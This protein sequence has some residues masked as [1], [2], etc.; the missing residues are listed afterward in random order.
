MDYMRFLFVAVGMCVVVSMSAQHENYLND[1]MP[2]SWVFVP[3]VDGKAISVDDKWWTR[4]DD[5]MLDSLVSAAMR[6][7]YDIRHAARRVTMARA[8]TSIARSEFYPTVDLYAAA[9]TKRTSGRQSGSS[10][11]AD[12]EGY[13]ELGADINWQVDL[14]GKISAKTD[15]KKKLWQASQAEWAGVMLTVAGE[16]VKHYVNLRLFQENLDILHERSKSQLEIVRFVEE[17]QVGDGVSSLQV[18]QALTLYYSMLAEVPVVENLVRSEINAIAMLLGIYPD[19]LFELLHAR[20]KKHWPDYRQLIASGVPSDLLR[21]RPDIVEAEKV[22]ASYAAA[23]GVAKKE[24]LPNLYIQGNISASARNLGHILDGQAYGWEIT[25]TLSWNLFDGYYRKNQEKIARETL[26]EG[27]DNYNITVLNAYQ[28]TSNALSS[29]SSCIKQIDLL[30]DAVTQAR[31][32]L[33]QATDNYKI[34]LCDF[35]NVTDAQNTLMQQ[36]NALAQARR[37]A[38]VSLVKVYVALGGGWDESS[39]SE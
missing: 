39:I 13:W 1:S 20:R 29:Y 18:T 19:Q 14:F 9:K 36:Q 7:N 30:G 35:Q 17:H 27:I 25:P 11:R 26:Q 6:A 33:T 31:K 4:F 38:L 24:F 12:L 5:E 32:A 34:G 8:A 2:A 37:N 28:E 10:G 16:M 23:L 22:I 21:R 3:G 15:A